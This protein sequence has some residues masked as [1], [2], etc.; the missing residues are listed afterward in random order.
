MGLFTE[1]RTMIVMEVSAE[2]L[3]DELNVSIELA[4]ADGRGPNVFV[5]DRGDK[6][7]VPKAG[8]EVNLSAMKYAWKK[9][10]EVEGEERITMKGIGRIKGSNIELRS[11]RIA[12][13]CEKATDDLERAFAN[14]DAPK[15]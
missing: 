7:R 12:N 4:P 3:R 6:L 8:S 10:H 11:G 14:L 15:Q 5:T 13:Y 9:V 1:T 2:R